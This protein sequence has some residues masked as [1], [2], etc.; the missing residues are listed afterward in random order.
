[1][2]DPLQV[3]LKSTVALGIMAEEREKHQYRLES[4]IVVDLTAQYWTVVAHGSLMTNHV[5]EGKMKTDFI[6]NVLIL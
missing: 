6:N 2:D 4:S 3:H 5:L 1:M